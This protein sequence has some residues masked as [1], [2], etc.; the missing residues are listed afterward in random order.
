MLRRG[1]TGLLPF[2]VE[3]C[4][5]RFNVGFVVLVWEDMCEVNCLDGNTHSLNQ[6]FTDAKPTLSRRRR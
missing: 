4:D 1:A 3:G 5:C 2:S 6:H